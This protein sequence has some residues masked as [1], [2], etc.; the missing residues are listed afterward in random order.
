MLA[1]VAL[2]G[3][4][5]VPAVALASELGV[6]KLLRFLV[7]GRL[8]H[9]RQGRRRTTGSGSRW[10]MPRSGSTSSSPPTRPLRAAANGS[11]ADLARERLRRRSRRI[12]SPRTA[13]W[14]TDILSDDEAREFVFGRGGSL[15][16]PF[17]V[18]VKTGTSQAYHDNWTVGY[19][20]HVTVGVW[21]GNFD[22]TP[23]RNSSGVTGAA[24]IFH[25]VMLAAE[26]VARGGLAATD[27]TAILPPVAAPR[28]GRSARFRVCRPTPGARPADTS[29][30][31]WNH[32]RCHAA[33]ITA[34]TKAC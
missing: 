2:A 33:G 6:P 16:F 17:P 11:S 8:G 4:E 1:R 34:R 22:R 15:E 7:A 28:S 18:A 31:A 3:S 13:F 10:A 21:V 25:G 24:P 29:G 14:I 23:L 32:R 9:L 20:K 12:V 27:S 26:R 30:S 5:N 19:S